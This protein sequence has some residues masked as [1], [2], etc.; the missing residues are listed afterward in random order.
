MKKIIKFASLS[1]LAAALAVTPAVSRAQDAATNAPAV[2]PAAGA[3][4]NAPAVHKKK[5]A[6]GFPFHGK[7]TALDASA[8][9]VTVGEFKLLSLTVTS[10]TKI[11]TNGVPAT[12][13]DFKVG[14]SVTGYYKKAA[15]G[16]LNLTTLK[17]A[18]KK[19]AAAE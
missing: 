17:F 11:S 10:T 3:G 8:G 4:T 16:A 1:L 6:T 2:V 7:I 5:K 13:A 14:D 19:K 12:L 15:D 18:K 9:T